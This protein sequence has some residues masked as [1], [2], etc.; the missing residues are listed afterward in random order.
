MET[1]NRPTFSQTVDKL[2]DWYFKD[3]LKHGSC[4]HCVVGNL[5]GGS[6]L[7]S[8]LFMTDECTGKQLA[9]QYGSSTF[10]LFKFASEFQLLYGATQVCLKTGYMVNELARI[11]HAFETAPK[12]KS[13]DEYMF[14]GLMAVVD[15]LADIHGVDL[16]TKEKYKFKFQ[17]ETQ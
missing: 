10:R 11:E 7:W 4:A 15:V 17:I 14:N 5:C 12:G 9:Q 16:Q 1:F 6:T 2:I 8:Y 3:E 13:A